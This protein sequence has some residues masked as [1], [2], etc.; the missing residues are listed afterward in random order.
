M[1]QPHD[2]ND[3]S[4]KGCQYNPKISILPLLIQILG[5]QMLL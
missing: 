4:V 5:K 1:I 3:R 2:N